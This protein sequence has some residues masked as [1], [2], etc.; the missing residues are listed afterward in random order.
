MVLF[1]ALDI[2]INIIEKG[3]LILLFSNEASSP[4]RHTAK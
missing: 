4:A 3:E 1:R 2:G